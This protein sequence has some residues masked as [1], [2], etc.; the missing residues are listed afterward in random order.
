MYIYC[1][2]GRNW[3]G[4][5]SCRVESLMGAGGWQVWRL[6]GGVR[7]SGLKFAGVVEQRI[8]SSTL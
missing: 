5:N 6:K 8:H 7:S 1:N 4:I 3:D 2:Y